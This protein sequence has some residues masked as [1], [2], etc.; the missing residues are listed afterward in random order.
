MEWN[1]VELTRI[2]IGNALPSYFKYFHK[3]YLLNYK[4]CLLYKKKIH[5]YII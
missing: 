1:V 3:N 4:Y 5:I 2:E